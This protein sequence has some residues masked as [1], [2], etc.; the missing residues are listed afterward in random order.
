MA[1]VAVDHRAEQVLVRQELLE[2]TTHGLVVCAVRRAE[3]N[4]QHPDLAE[5]VQQGADA[6]V[7]HL[8]VLE[9]I[10]FRVDHDAQGRDLQG[11]HE[12]VVVVRDDGFK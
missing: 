1:E 3:V 4:E 11:V 7:H 6:D 12:G 10:G 8:V 9:V 2:I 5:I